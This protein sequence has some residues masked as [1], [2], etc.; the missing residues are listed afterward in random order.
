MFKKAE[1]KRSKLRLALTGPSGSGKTWSALVIAKGL[2]GKTAVLDTENGSAQ[3]YSDIFDFDVAELAPPYSPDRFIA[4]IEFAEKNGY[5]NLIIDS[6]THEWQ[7]RGGILEIH[8]NIFKSMK[9]PNS[10]TAWKRP[11][12]LHQEFVDAI[13]HSKINIIATMR[14]K[15]E[16]VQS[17]EGGRSKVEKVGMASVQ[18]SGIEYEFTTVFDLSINGNLATCSKDRTKLFPP[19]GAPFVITETTAHVIKDWLDSGK[20]EDEADYK[21]SDFAIASAPRWIAK[22]S[23][24]VKQ[25]GFDQAIESVKDHFQ[26]ADVQYMIG[27]LTEAK[28]IAEAKLES[29]PDDAPSGSRRS[30]NNQAASPAMLSM[31]DVE[32]KMPV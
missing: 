25:G 8:E 24:M 6:I 17:N 13:L 14:A 11:K 5:D 23:R 9:N 12:E 18:S 30:S 27:K 2:G 28:I 10:Y 29:L 31:V 15:S 1:K 21:P 32:E 7:G 20:E 26:G 4:A 3:L 22:A 16:Y 19:G